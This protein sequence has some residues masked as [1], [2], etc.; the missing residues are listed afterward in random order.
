MNTYDLV[1]AVLANEPEG[2][3]VGRTLLQKKLYFLK[4][5]TS[6]RIQFYPHYYGPY[7]REVAETV[8]SL[9]SAGILRERAESFPSFETPWGESTRYSY[10]FSSN[11]R[12]VISDI[13][14][15]RMGRTRYSRIR[16]IL[17]TINGRPEANDYKL[18][19]IAAKVFQILNEKGEMRL[20]DFPKEA[21]KLK[22]KL[23]TNDVKKA[24]SFLKG[25]GLL[26]EKQQ[27]A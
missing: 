2:C 26:T 15:K 17:E 1:L 4:E 9:V 20:S 10:D 25:I 8:D 24:A 12:D 27:R 22:W 13:L 16:K 21:R 7:S 3:M 18:P 19:S 23:N 11:V 6:A 14:E 5:I